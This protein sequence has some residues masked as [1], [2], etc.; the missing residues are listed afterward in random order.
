LKTVFPDAMILKISDVRNLSTQ[1]ENNAQW[2]KNLDHMIDDAVPGEKDI[3]FFWG[4][5]EDV[6]FFE[7]AGKKIQ[8]LN[9]FDWSTRKISATEVRDFIAWL[10]LTEKNHIIRRERLL[11]KDFVNPLIVDDVLQ[12]FEQEREKFKKK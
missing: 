8:Y 10:I 6:D 12:T 5:F 9:R 1:A 11:E 4:C 3:T 2:I 7:E